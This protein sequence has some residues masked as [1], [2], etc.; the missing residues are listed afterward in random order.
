MGNGALSLHPIHPLSQQLRVAG[1]VCR[2]P[3]GE[4]D[5]PEY[6]T[7]MSPYCPPNV[8]LQNG[9]SCKDGSSYCYSGVCASLDEQ[10]QMLWGPS[11]CHMLH[12]DESDDSHL[13]SR[14]IVVESLFSPPL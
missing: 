12:S 8:F 6:C 1:S 2:E 14:F 9:G 4:C 7:G 13:E 11:E 3:L 5:L 10:C